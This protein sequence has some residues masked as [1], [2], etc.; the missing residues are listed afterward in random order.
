M[1]YKIFTRLI[2]LTMQNAGV[3]GAAENAAGILPNAHA[4]L[5]LAGW[6]IRLIGLSKG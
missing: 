5:T 2:S 6:V 3:K 4:V 1:L